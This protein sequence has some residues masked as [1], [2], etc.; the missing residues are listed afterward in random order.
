MM[1]QLSFFL[2]LACECEENGRNLRIN[3]SRNI[4]HMCLEEFLDRIIEY[5]NLRIM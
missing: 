1:S 2:V 4:L 3:L 5:Y